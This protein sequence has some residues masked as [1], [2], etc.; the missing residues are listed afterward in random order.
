[1]DFEILLRRYWTKGEILELKVKCDCDNEFNTSVY[2]NT[3]YFFEC[4]K[5]KR[6][7]ILNNVTTYEP[8]E[9]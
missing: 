2:Q 5:C 1:M 3:S 9:V 6:S 8:I 4:P 7:W